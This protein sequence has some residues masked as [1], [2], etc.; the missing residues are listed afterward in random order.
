MGEGGESQLHLEITKDSRSDLA[1]NGS[2][3]LDSD[4]QGSKEC[5]SECGT[6]PSRHFEI[7][8]ESFICDSLDLDEPASYKEALASP[9]SHEWIGSMRDEMDSMATFKSENKH[10][11][12]ILPN[13]AMT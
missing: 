12:G 13:I 4:T 3:P 10:K 1:P 8:G 9:T 7:E 5:R 2:K 11:M 6:I